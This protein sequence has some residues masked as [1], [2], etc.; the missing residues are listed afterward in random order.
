MLPSA[1]FGESCCTSSRNSRRDLRALG[2][3]E[4]RSMLYSSSSSSSSVSMKVSNCFCSACARACRSSNSRTASSFALIVRSLM[5]RSLSSHARFASGVSPYR[6]IHSAGML[7]CLL[8]FLGVLSP[9]WGVYLCLFW[10]LG[11]WKELR[12]GWAKRELSVYPYGGLR[13]NP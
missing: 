9:V 2:A 6:A 7:G 4:V 5:R 3:S 12:T 8:R 13:S 1:S 10:G 11:V